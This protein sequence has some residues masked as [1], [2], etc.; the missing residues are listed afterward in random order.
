[1]R[2]LKSATRGAVAGCFVMAGSGAAFAGGWDTMGVGTLDLL[3]APERFVVEGGATY[4]DRNTDY[5]VTS[6]SDQLGR[7]TTSG[8]TSERVTPNIWNYQ[9]GVKGRVLENVDCLGRAYNPYGIIESMDPTW[10]ARYAG[11]ETNATTLGLDATC[12]YTFQAG[13]GRSI[14]AI[15]G[16]RGLDLTYQSDSMLPGVLVN[17][18]LTDDYVSG[19]EL[20]SKGMSWGW[21]AGVAY[22]IPAYALRAS[23]V[24]DSQ[25]AMDLEGETYIRDVPDGLGGTTTITGDA[26]SSI[27]APQSVEL[28]IQ[29][30]IAPGWLAS[31]GV[32]WVDWSGIDRL[33]VKDESGDLSTDRALNFKDGWTVEAGVGHQLNEKLTLGGSVQWDRGVGG[34]YSDSYSFGLGGSYALNDKVNMI[35]GGA[36]VYTAAGEADATNHAPYGA[37]NEYTYDSAWHYALSTKL[38]I[39]F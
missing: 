30:G 20:K 19:A 7:Q 5:D 34:S 33:V 25:I 31:F 23:L 37:T 26:Y 22:E 6:A 10:A 17:P 15:A 12:S 38:R 2:F 28:N 11:Y 14:R 13:E 4:L 3:F 8:S 29:S 18:A 39:A 24:Y 21:R 27:T 32:K 36:A 9:F 1:M 35:I 16:I